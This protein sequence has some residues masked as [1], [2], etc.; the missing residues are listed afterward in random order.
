MLWSLHTLLPAH[1]MLIDTWFVFSVSRW[2]RYIYNDSFVN[3][4]P[5]HQIAS[6]KVQGTSSFFFSFGRR[7]APC[8]PEDPS[9]AGCSRV[10]FPLPSWTVAAAEGSVS[11]AS[12]PA[13]VECM[14][15]DQGAGA[16]GVT[17]RSYH[18]DLGATSTAIINSGLHV[19]DCGAFRA[20]LTS[21]EPIRR[22]RVQAND[23]N[24]YAWHNI[25]LFGLKCGV[26]NH[27]AMSCTD[28][29]T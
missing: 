20:L 9:S 14:P 29:A 13:S 2:Y 18:N 28:I 11:S 16:S 6:G 25:G 24:S 7:P 8:L 15:R 1:K 17:E 3:V 5:Q 26:H 10:C 4:E 21:Q 12:L 19:N 27:Y 22:F 23:E